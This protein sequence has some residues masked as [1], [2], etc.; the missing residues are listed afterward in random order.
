M[1]TSP[2]VGHGLDGSPM[3][4]QAEKI[5]TSL[6]ELLD[7][8]VAPPDESQAI[9]EILDIS[10]PVVFCQRVLDS[11]EFRQYILKGI[12]E[13]DIPPAVMC[14]VIDHAWGKP[15]DRVEHSGQVNQ[16]IT[17]VRRVIVRVERDDEMLIGETV[18]QG[19]EPT[20]H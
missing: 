16:I 7:G 6:K 15:I 11:R 1:E 12:T 18:E 5:P 13:R 3:P 10:D 20:K 17:E 19:S 4:L 9:A 2:C 8:P 14:R